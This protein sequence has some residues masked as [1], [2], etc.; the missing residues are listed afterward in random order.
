MLLPR[1]EASESPSVSFLE[2]PVMECRWRAADHQLSDNR[3]LRCLS[4]TWWYLGDLLC[5]HDRWE[6]GCYG[7]ETE[8]GSFND[9]WFDTTR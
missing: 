1:V 2:S 6:D 7:D 9:L 4:P 3:A 5:Y 8:E